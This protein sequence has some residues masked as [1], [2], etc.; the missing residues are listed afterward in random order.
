MTSGSRRPILW[1]VIRD[2]VTFG[3]N[4]ETVGHRRNFWEQQT[5]R[6]RLWG[7]CSEERRG[8]R[9]GTNYSPVYS[10]VPSRSAGVR[11]RPSTRDAGHTSFYA[12]NYMWNRLSQSLH[13]NSPSTSPKFRVKGPRNLF[14]E[15]GT[16]ETEVNFLIPN[17]SN[18]TF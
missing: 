6:L 8:G 2:S 12:G 7:F 13:Q 11:N 14:T 9:R 10:E 3:Q 18:L 4:G 5:I 17:I 15:L 1:R 16:L